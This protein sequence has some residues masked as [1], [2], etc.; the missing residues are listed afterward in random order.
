MHDGELGW[1]E[2]GAADER[3][4]RSAGGG[5]MLR[6][7]LVP[8]SLSHSIDSPCAGQTD[9]ALHCCAMTRQ[10]A[11][12]GRW[13]V[14]VGSGGPIVSGAAGRCSSRCGDARL[15]FP[16]QQVNGRAHTCLRT[17]LAPDGSMT[18]IATIR[19]IGS[20][21]LAIN[22]KGTK[23]SEPNSPRLVAFLFVSLWLLVVSS[24]RPP[25]PTASSQM[26]TRRRGGREGR[27]S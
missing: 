16:L 12:A 4:G 15:S 21:S 2:L 9:A 19:R 10:P 8:F 14:R 13:R 27:E 20:F 24:L 26:D 18:A 11:E 1:A 23:G 7:C 22:Q 25:H 17:S 5:H 3:S 6:A